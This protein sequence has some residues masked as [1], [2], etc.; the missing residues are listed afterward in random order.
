MLWAASRLAVTTDSLFDLPVM[1]NIQIRLVSASTT[2]SLFIQEMGQD[3]SETGH[4]RG[5]AWAL[6]TAH[7]K[8]LL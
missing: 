5:P 7:R 3:N 6:L 2:L 4:T 8:S 1:Q